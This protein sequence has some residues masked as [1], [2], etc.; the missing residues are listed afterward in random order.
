MNPGILYL[1]YIIIPTIFLSVTFSLNEVK[2]SKTYLNLYTEG[3]RYKVK[4]D[5]FDLTKGSICEIICQNC[6]EI[7]ENDGFI[8]KQLSDSTYCWVIDTIT[9]KEKKYMK[10]YEV[11]FVEVNKFNEYFEQI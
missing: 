8:M 3:D 9:D 5:F 4:K 6:Y 1:L 7:K 10:D 2:K 11:P